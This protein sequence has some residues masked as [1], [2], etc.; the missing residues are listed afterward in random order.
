MKK[1]CDEITEKPRICFPS[2]ELSSILR[3]KIIEKSVK[4]PE[5]KE[6]FS[7]SILV[8]IF[9]SIT[10]ILQIK[11]G[12]GNSPFLFVSQFLII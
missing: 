10:L 6:N 4:N 2:K 3:V 9:L 1:E 12:R 7:F 5:S 8:I 11:R